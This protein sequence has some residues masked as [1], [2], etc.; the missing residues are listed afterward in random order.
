MSF[1]NFQ[2]LTGLNAITHWSLGICP[3]SDVNPI[4]TG[5]A[6]ISGPTSITVSVPESICHE[7]LSGDKL[8]ILNLPLTPTPLVATISYHVLA[9]Y[10]DP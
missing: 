7:N 10:P 8:F 2:Y 5:P 9:L 4:L 1:I 3:V 6:V